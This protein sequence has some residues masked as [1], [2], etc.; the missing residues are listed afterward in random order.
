MELIETTKKKPSLFDGSGWNHKLV[1]CERKKNGAEEQ[2]TPDVAKT[3]IAK[4]LSTARKRLRE[5]DTPVRSIYNDAIRP[6]IDAGYEFVAEVPT[7]DEVKAGF[8]RKSALKE[9]SEF[10]IDGTFKTCSKQF[11]QLYTFHIDVSSNF[12]ERDAF[13]VVFTLLSDKKQQ[14]YHRLF[15]EM[16]NIGWNPQSVHLDFE[17]AIINALTTIFPGIKLHVGLASVYKQ[18]EDI[19]MHVRKCGSMAYLPLDIID[20]A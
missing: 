8:Y 3:E 4:S 6:L 1:V 16:K 9:Y 5:E 11:T 20:D 13:S 10:F 7:F 15:E 12:D 14:T 17:I 18:N 2:C 19:Q